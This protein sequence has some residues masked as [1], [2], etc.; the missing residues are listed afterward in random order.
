VA[1]VPAA[2]QEAASPTPLVLTDFEIN[3]TRAAIGP[4]QPLEHAV[5]YSERVT[6]SHAQ[7]SFAV[8]FAGLRYSNPE[9]TRY[10]YRLQG[11]DTSWHE[12]PSSIRQA[13][14]TTLPTGRYELQVQVAADRGEW[15]TPTLSLG[16]LILPVWWATWWFRTA[17]ALLLGLLAWG[18]VHARVRYVAREVT[19]QLEARNNERIRI[20]QDLHDTLLQGLLSA[21]MQLSVAQDQVSPEGGARPLLE[22]VS[23]LLRQLVIEGRNAVRGLRTWNFDSDD[24][25][26]A[27]SSI[28]GDLQIESP[29]GFRVIVEGEST[30]LLPVARGELYLIVREAVSNALRHSR[31][32]LI[33]VSLEY[34][35]DRFR[36]TVRDDG[37]GFTTDAA[38]MG[39]EDHFGLTVMNERAHRLG[40]LLSV[41]SG[42][43]LG[44]EIVLSVPGRCVYLPERIGSL[45]RSTSP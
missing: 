20:A 28:P 31:A 6:L 32:S 1:F 37:E 35:P 12:S 43:D 44:T 26:R 34:L 16:I 19:T 27:I 8:K 4:G 30:P 22:R 17:C 14:Y 2:L 40:A 33:E 18:L 9:T 45:P 42:P 41:S 7:R 38:G 39:R 24:L 23:N 11:L 25:E 15:Q 29:A 10:R 21:S 3:G 13:T 5:A 36:L